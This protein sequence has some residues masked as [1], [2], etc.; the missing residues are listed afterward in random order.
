MCMIT[1][2]SSCSN[3]WVFV[4]GPGQSKGSGRLCMRVELLGGAGH[5]TGRGW[6]FLTYLLPRRLSQPP[7][8][9]LTPLSGLL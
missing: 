2:A 1:H 4:V 5:V 7:S 6:A 8:K 9:A 3:L